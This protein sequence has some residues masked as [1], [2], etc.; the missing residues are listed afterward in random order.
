[1]GEKSNNTGS[2][3]SAWNPGVEHV[4]WTSEFKDC[5]FQSSRLSTIPT[6]NMIKDNRYGNR[7]KITRTSSKI[8]QSIKTYIFLLFTMVGPNQPSNVLL[9]LNLRIFYIFFVSWPNLPDKLRLLSKWYQV[10]VW[11]KMSNDDVTT[12]DGFSNFSFSF[13]FRQ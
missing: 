10:F 5:L 6:F 9:R 4:F 8:F 1:M 3:M 7:G 11:R 13:S 12:A 2:A